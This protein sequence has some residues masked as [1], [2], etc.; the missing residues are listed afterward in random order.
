MCTIFYNGKLFGLRSGEHRLL[1]LCN[2]FVKEN[3][4]TFD[5][6]LR[7][8]TFHGG[9]RDLKKEPR[10]IKHKCHEVG[11]QHDRCLATLYSVSRL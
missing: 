10:F 2:N 7:S 9:L 1:R 5:E 6:S 8:E 4:I 3:Y 11:H